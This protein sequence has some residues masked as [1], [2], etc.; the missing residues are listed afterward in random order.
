M[1]LA[2]SNSFLNCVMGTITQHV[3][4]KIVVRIKRNFVFE[5]FGT[6]PS[7]YVVGRTHGYH[8]VH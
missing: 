6:V 8:E 1:D 7:R 2:S 3:L 5:V 4:P